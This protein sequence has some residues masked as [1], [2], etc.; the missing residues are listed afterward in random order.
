MNLT[1]LAVL[2]V[3]VILTGCAPK[4]VQAVAAPPPPPPTIEQAPDIQVVND[5]SPTE[6]PAAA[7][8]PAPTDEATAGPVAVRVNDAADFQQPL[9]THGTWQIIEPYG[10][11]WRPAHI[12]ADWRPYGDGHWLWTEGGWYWVSDEP[13]AWACYHYGRWVWDARC[14]WVWI[15]GTEWAPAWVAWRENDDYV[16]WAPLP[17]AFEFVAVHVTVPC[18]P[19]VIPAR[20]FVFVERRRF[21]E[22]I[23]RTVHVHHTTIINQTINVTKIKRVNNVII[24]EGPNLAALERATA[25][26]LKAVRIRALPHS[27]LSAPA[28]VAAVVA[29]TKHM[30]P[31]P[32]P[33]LRVNQPR[34]REATKVEAPRRSEPTES[35]KRERER[36]VRHAVTAVAPAPAP[37][38]TPS[39][40]E[41]PDHP[42]LRI[43]R[44]DNSKRDREP[45]MSK[46]SLP[47]AS[48]TAELPPRKRERSERQIAPALT[49]SPPPVAAF[50]SPP[51]QPAAPEVRRPK[52]VEPPVRFVQG[53]LPADPAPVAPP[54]PAE[55]PTRQEKRIVIAR[56]FAP[57]VPEQPVVRETSSKRD[58]ES[59]LGTSHAPRGR[60]ENDAKH[61]D[62]RPS[63]KDQP[64]R[65]EPTHKRWARN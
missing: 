39:P 48:Q 56:E 25:R 61:A 35:A 33:V 34:E 42:K 12:A 18:R 49:P 23:R 24:N 21:C 30:R 31:Q 20:A 44:E 37:V 57:P 65:H 53:S 16:G 3:S 14:G 36:D 40:N 13:W 51:A 5:D 4:P 15:P 10:M 64:D 32:Q 54:L 29:P 60:E 28:D 7:S 38:V 27:R 50:P 59:S 45:A 17:P 58:R 11:T 63:K 1:N 8:L 55:R 62:E 9:A 46:G 22:P 47:R 52:N 19:V 26:P 43:A 2:S 6:S 41:R